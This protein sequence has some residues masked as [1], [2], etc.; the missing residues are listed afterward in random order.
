MGA[1]ESVGGNHVNDLF[2][3]SGLHRLVMH[4]TAGAAGVIALELKH[5]HGVTGSDAVWHAGK[6]KPE[7][8]AMPTTGHYAAHTLNLN[9]GSIGE[10]LDAM[11]GAKERPF[12]GGKNPINKAQLAEFAKRCK[13]RCDAYR[14]PIEKWS[15]LSHAEVQPVL[16]VKQKNKW[17]VCWL[18]GMAA[19]KSPEYVGDMLREMIRAA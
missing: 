15:V 5:Y 8:N 18:P 7:A 3:A 13:M 19:P 1:I 10:A 9:T 2:H 16:G 4:W 11:A 14:I 12:D 17:D 6:F